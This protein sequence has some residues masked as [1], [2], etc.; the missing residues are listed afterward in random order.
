M[1]KRRI[2]PLLLALVLVFSGCSGR[3][4]KTTENGTDYLTII[5]QD[6]YGQDTE[7]NR[8]MERSVS[9]KIVR[10]EEDSITVTV[11]APD[12]CQEALNWLETVSDE[13]FTE[14]AL[15]QKLISLMEGKPQSRQFTLKLQDG[16]VIYTNDFLNAASCG[17]RRFHTALEVM[18]MEEMEESI[19]D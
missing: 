15:R 4:S 17:V 16:N 14:Q 1:G 11:T 13:D 5:R 12:V 19:D 7:L 18:L 6:L 8:A 3:K 9:L 2:L 10:V